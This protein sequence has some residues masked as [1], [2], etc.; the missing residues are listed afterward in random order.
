MRCRSRIRRGERETALIHRFGQRVLKCAS[1][2][3]TQARSFV[4]DLRRAAHKFPRICADTLHSTASGKERG[5]ETPPKSLIS[6]LRP[7]ISP[8]IKRLCPAA[9]GREDRAAAGYQ[10]GD[11]S[12]HVLDRVRACLCASLPRRSAEPMR[13][14][15]VR[16]T[17]K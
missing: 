2:S 6:F 16:G 1:A 9:S 3:V 12:V 7:L 10:W 15:R 5:S 4:P 11:W 8:S 14:R 17:K 13:P